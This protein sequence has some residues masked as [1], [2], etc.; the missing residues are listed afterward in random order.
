MIKLQIVVSSSIDLNLYF[1]WT[2]CFQSIHVVVVI[3]GCGWR[4]VILRKCVRL[5]F[6]WTYFRIEVCVCSCRRIT[7]FLT[8]FFKNRLTFKIMQT[9]ENMGERSEIPFKIFVFWKAIRSFAI[10]EGQRIHSN[11]RYYCCDIDFFIVSYR[12]SAF[13]RVNGFFAVI[14][15]IMD[16]PIGEFTNNYMLKHNG[17]SDLYLSPFWRVSAICS[18]IKFC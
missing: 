5:F 1:Y 12:T 9:R 11:P 10:I 7:F 4:F 15:Y 2:F 18:L 16:Y 17:I 13:N 3:V 6:Q 8:R 14:F